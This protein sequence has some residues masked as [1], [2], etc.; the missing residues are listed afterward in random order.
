MIHKIKDSQLFVQSS[1]YNCQFNNKIGVLF[2]NCKL[3]YYRKSNK[4]YFKIRMEFYMTI[5]KATIRDINVI[6]GIIKDAIIDMESQGIFQWDNIYPN[7]DVISKD[8]YKEN[9]YVYLDDNIIKGFIVLNEFQDK[10]YEM[11]KWKYDTYK[12]LI[13][14]RLCINPKYKGRGIATALIKFAEVFGEDNKYEAIRLDSFINNSNACRL[15]AKNGYEK[16]GIVNFRKGEFWCLEKK[17]ETDE[18][19][20]VFYK[21]NELQIKYEVVNHM[22][23]YTIDDID[24]FGITEDGEVCKNLFLRDASGKRHFLIIL[25]K[26]KK[27]DL[28]KIRIELKTTA[29]S[30]ASE[31]R[32]EKYMG[33][34]KGAVTPFGIL[35]DNNCEVEVVFDKDLIGNSKLGFHPNVNTA[36]LWISFEDVKKIIEHN[37]NS[38]LYMNI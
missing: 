12:N 27:A 34:K 8:I 19:Q 21:L 9:L 16:R 28:K 24:T 3:W 25:K 22:P 23:A 10:E 26:D 35:N 7:K 29:L 5:K 2:L 31:E 15:Y 20:K 36:T 32:L 38:L 6:M 13:I 1:E 18:Q 11:I 33:L 4:Q 37:G 30:F 17:L 14:H